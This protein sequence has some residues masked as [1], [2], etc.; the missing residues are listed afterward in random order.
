[1]YVFPLRFRFAKTSTNRRIVNLHPTHTSLF[2]LK[3]KKLQM[4]SRELFTAMQV[5]FS[6]VSSSFVVQL[7]R[8]F[9]A[10]GL[11]FFDTCC[12]GITALMAMVV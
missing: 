6:H 5:R 9:V 11:W 2:S 10:A 4:T 7:M 3:K 12:F 1:M 8:L